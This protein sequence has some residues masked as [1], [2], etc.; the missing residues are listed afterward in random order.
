MHHM[1]TSIPTQFILSILHYPGNGSHGNQQAK[2]A[3]LRLLNQTE[4]KDAVRSDKVADKNLETEMKTQ[5]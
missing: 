1:H 3:P 2:R 4:Q 5:K